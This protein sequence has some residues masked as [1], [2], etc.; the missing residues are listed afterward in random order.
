MK[1]EKTAKFIT[2]LNGFSGEARL[3]KVTPKLEGHSYVA[4][5]A[6]VVLYSGPETYIFP[7]NKKGEIEDW[8]EL[9]GSCQGGLS[10]EQALE[11]AGY[12][13]L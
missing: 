13:I 1:N 7:A 6:T 4:V 12:T 9:K 5:S 8:G 3:Y 11:N 2:K 10:H